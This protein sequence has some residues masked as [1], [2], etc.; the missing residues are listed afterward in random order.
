MYQAFETKMSAAL[1]V[2]NPEGMK[3]LR[4][5]RL[6]GRAVLQRTDQWLAVVYT[7][8]DLRVP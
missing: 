3:L 1:L 8:M 2:G 7:V 5:P 4:R 6:N